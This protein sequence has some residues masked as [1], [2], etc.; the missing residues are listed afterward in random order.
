MDAARNLRPTY[1]GEQNKLAWMADAR[2]ATKSKRAHHLRTAL[3]VLRSCQSTT[4]SEETKP[5]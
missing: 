2:I 4:G 1:Q 3:D 5:S